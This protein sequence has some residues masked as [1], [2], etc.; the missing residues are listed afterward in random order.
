MPYSEEGTAKHDAEKM[1]NINIAIPAELH[2]KLKL[3]SVEL[4]LTLKEHIIRV[5]ERRLKKK[6]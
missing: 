5:L 4:D 2:K 6:S 1:T 3:R